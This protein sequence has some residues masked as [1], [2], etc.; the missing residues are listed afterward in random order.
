MLAY[1]RRFN[2]AASACNALGEELKTKLFVRGLHPDIQNC[3]YPQKPPNLDS[4]ITEAV[5]AESELTRQRRLRYRQER[6]DTPNQQTVRAT[7]RAFEP[8]GTHVLRDPPTWP[9]RNAYRSTAPRGSSTRG[10]DPRTGA[11][12]IPLSAEPVCFACGQRGHLRAHCPQM[13]GN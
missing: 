9:G 13:Q 5:R 6:T 2:R 11:N 7:R 12:R 10:T 3:V 8:G 4:A 1:L